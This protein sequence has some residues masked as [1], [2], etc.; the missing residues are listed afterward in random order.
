MIDSR[1]LLWIA[2]PS[3]IAM[4]DLKS[5]QVENI[6]NL[7]GTPGAVGCSIIEDKNH[8]MWL[9]SEFV[10]THVKVDKDEEGKWYLKITNYNSLDGLQERQFNYRSACLMRNGDIA[11]GGQDGVNIISPRSAQ[12]AK[13]H[14]RALFSGVV[15]FDHALTAGEEY[16]GRVIL[17]ESLDAAIVLI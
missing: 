3:G 15:L 8:T 9:V 13:N 12:N 7:N 17:E 6:N 14:V 16:E 4:Y 5:N 1:G 11:I 10:V 2:T